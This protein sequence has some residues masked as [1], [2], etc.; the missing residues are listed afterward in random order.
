MKAAACAALLVISAASTGRAA[1][2]PVRPTPGAA[3]LATIRLSGV[4]YTDAR[5]FL[6]R[7]GLKAT[8]IQAASRLRFESSWTKIELEANSREASLNGT[9]LFLG[10]P[11]IARE[12]SLFIS[13]IDAEKLFGA[14]LRPAGITGDIPQLR[15]I[16]IDPGHGGIDPGKQ[17]AALKLD[18]KSVALDTSLRLKKLLEAE[19]YKVILTRSDDRHLSADKADDLRLRAEVANEAEA[20]LFISIHFN[21]VPPVDAARVQ[22]TETYTFTPQYQ[23][24]TA[25]GSRHA[26]DRVAAPGNRHDAWNAVLGYAVHRHL[27][28]GLG[29]PDRGLKRARFAVLKFVSCPAVLIEAGFL[30][31]DSEARRIGSAA[32]R[33][34]LAQAIAAGVRAY[35]IQLIAARK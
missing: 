18:E 8:W 23:R 25:D 6:A 30:S 17:H 34:D 13:R 26:A 3:S 28:A 14:I 35:D 22:G 7:Y 5:S 24:S 9:R 33:D 27:L 2:N 29:A 10:E 20:D 15:T 21:A 32:Y 19:G 16:V 31:N 11:V 4:E 1:G 12:R